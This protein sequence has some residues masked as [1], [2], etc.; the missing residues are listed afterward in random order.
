MTSTIFTTTAAAALLVLAGSVAP[1]VASDAPPAIFVVIEN[2]GVV[3]DPE[4]AATAISYTLGELTQLRRRR[5]TRD[6]QIHLIQTARPTEIAWS[7]TPAQLEEQ[8]HDVLALVTEFRATCSDLTLAYDQV[9]VTLRITRPP[10]VALINIGPFINAP[11]P[12]DQGDGLIT[13]PQAVAPEVQLGALA[14]EASQ[15]KL[16]NVHPDQDEVLL[17]HLE[18]AGVMTRVQAGDLDFDLL[19]PARTRGALGSILE[20]D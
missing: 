3:Q 11:F 10:E 13:L 16:I 20:E 9:A 18:A 15:L 7:G 17:D 19:D 8:G 1:A 5:A 6:T 12:C 2:G 4:A 14:L